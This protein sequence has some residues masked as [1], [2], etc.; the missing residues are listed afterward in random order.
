MGSTGPGC[1]E[2]S[3]GVAVASTA[4]LGMSTLEW[5]HVIGGWIAINPCT[6][7]PKC[8]FHRLHLTPGSSSPLRSRMG[9]S[10]VTGGTRM[11]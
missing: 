3:L 4:S 6:H 11:A 7:R 2:G 1:P 5:T 8:P 9:R 10:Q